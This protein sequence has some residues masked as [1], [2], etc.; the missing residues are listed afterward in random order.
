MN[1]IEYIIKSKETETLKFRPSNEF[2]SKLGINKKRFWQLVRNDKPA[3]IDELKK[4]ANLF[5]VDITELI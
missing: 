1:K 2:Y 3:T 5:E 4:I